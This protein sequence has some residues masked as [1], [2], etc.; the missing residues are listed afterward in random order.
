MACFKIGDIIPSV[1]NIKV[2]STNVIR[3]MNG[4]VQVWPCSIIQLV[5]GSWNSLTSTE[6]DPDSGT[7]YEQLYITGGSRFDF[8]KLFL[9]G[10]IINTATSTARVLSYT[11]QTATNLIA[12]ASELPPPS[13]IWEDVLYETTDTNT[14][15]KYSVGSNTWVPVPYGQ[16]TT[17]YA[18]DPVTWQ[19]NFEYTPPY[20]GTMGD[21]F[22]SESPSRVQ[23]TNIHPVLTMTLGGNIVTTG[24][25]VIPINETSTYTSLLQE[26]ESESTGCQNFRPTITGNICGTW[27]STMN[28]MVDNTWESLVSGSV[29]FSS[30]LNGETISTIEGLTNIQLNSY[31]SIDLN[32]YSASPSIITTNGSN[33]VEFSFTNLQGTD[34]KPVDTLY[35]TG[36]IYTDAGRILNVNVISAFGT[37]EPALPGGGRSFAQPC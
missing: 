3:I 11:A 27:S 28:P 8:Y 25:R 26:R 6:Y 37:Y 14:I 20:V 4:S 5:C 32:I 10:E 15:Y 21:P 17:T 7:Y 2:G 18:V 23:N 9:P 12:N 29:D 19:I 35:F 31:K 24:G 36:T 22:S 16:E 34:D 33:V 30:V 13:P 1:G